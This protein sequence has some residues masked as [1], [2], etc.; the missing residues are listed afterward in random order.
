VAALQA[1]RSYHDGG[2]YIASGAGGGVPENIVFQ[3][4]TIL[5]KPDHGTYCSGFTF[6]VAM[7]AAA[8]RDL[9]AGK[10]VSQVREF[11][12]LWFATDPNKA[13]WEKQCVLA[14]TTL[15]IGL[16]SSTDPQPGDFVQMY[17]KVD[18][19]D[20]AGHSAVFLGWVTDTQGKR[21]G[22]KFR[23]SQTNTDGIGDATVYFSDSGHAP[24][25]TFPGHMSRSRIYFGRLK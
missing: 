15:G 17:R 16:D 14:L 20:P 9:L 13:D 11:Q 18:A 7:K 2:G 6:A 12:R 24:D 23:S 10:T 3:G 4:Q 25:A 5:S 19:G 1:A 8:Q 22:L 21:I